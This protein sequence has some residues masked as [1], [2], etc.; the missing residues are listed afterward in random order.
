M[1]QDTTSY[2]RYLH[3]FTLI[4]TVP[5]AVYRYLPFSHG[6]P[7]PNVNDALFQHL[8]EGIK[9]YAIFMISREGTIV[10]WNPGVKRLLGYD[11]AEFIGKPFSLIFTDEDIKLNIPESELTAVEKNGK[12][13]DE[14]WH[15]KKDGTVFWASGL[16]TLM[17]EPDG[18]VNGFT[19]I[20]R[21]QTQKK[22]FEERMA[23]QAN[24]LA[25]ANTELTNFAGVLSHDLK[26]PLQTVQGFANILQEQKG[27]DKEALKSVH[28]IMDGTK[29][30]I[31]L[32]NELLEYTTLVKSD[33]AMSFVDTAALLQDVL[34]SLTA[35]IT[36]H[37]ATVH[38]TALPTVWANSVQLGRV[39]QNL[40][41]NAIKYSSPD[42][43]PDIKISAR[44]SESETVFLVEDNGIGINEAEIVR[45]FTLFGRLHPE[46][47]VSGKGIGLSTCRKI[48]ESF[49]GRMWVRSKLNAGSVFSFS[50]PHPIEANAKATEIVTQRVEGNP[51]MPSEP[52]LA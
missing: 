1:A 16:V 47:E 29:R 37:N 42:R 13:E 40:I 14:R 27:L 23:E 3:H 45:L 18:T 39:F 26:A 32:V 5:S 22:Q 15:R 30:M 10:T 20:M 51:E 25:I 12:A 44:D 21:D 34:V 4:K 43:I 19:K 28:Y 8:I 38:A 2:L 11:E 52:R 24:A 9:E 36:K 35:A 33:E 48:V 41:E 7:M 46:T 31:N 50:V 49:G 17:K 6:I